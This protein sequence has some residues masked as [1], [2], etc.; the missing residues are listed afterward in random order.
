MS[1][2]EQRNPVKLGSSRQA[3]DAPRSGRSR[4]LDHRRQAVASAIASVQASSASR[5]GY[6]CTTTLH[7]FRHDLPL[8]VTTLEPPLSDVRLSAKFDAMSPKV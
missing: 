6:L 4:R 5:A 8:A 2:M 1:I 7:A 3:R